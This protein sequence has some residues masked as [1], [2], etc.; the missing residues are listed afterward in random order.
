MN[1]I[2]LLVL[3]FLSINSVYAVAAPTQ[4]IVQAT[5][6]RVVQATQNTALNYGGVNVFIPRG[7]TVIL[8]QQSDSSVVVRGHQLLG[9]KL[10]GATLFSRGPASV[11]FNPTSHIITVNYGDVH[12]TDTLGNT[13]LVSRGM[14]VSAKDV[15]K[16]IKIRK[17]APRKKHVDYLDDEQTLPTDEFVNERIL[18]AS[19][20]QATQDLQETLAYEE[21]TLSPSAPH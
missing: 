7:Q 11:S 4:K 14:S 20:R 17:K 8:G 3:V 12:I 6:T 15:R 13:T 21:E 9:I 19:Y 18:G 1:K 2:L 10:G 5:H 16:E